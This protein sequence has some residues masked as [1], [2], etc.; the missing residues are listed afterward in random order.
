MPS[1]SVLLEIVFYEPQGIPACS[2]N[3]THRMAVHF[4]WH[5]SMIIYAYIFIQ[6]KTVRQTY[7]VCVSTWF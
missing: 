3:V 6:V 5:M 2:Y 7:I 1:S 4:V